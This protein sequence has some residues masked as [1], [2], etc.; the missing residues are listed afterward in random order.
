MNWAFLGYGK[1]AIQFHESLKEFSDQKVYAIASRSKADEM[2]QQY[3]D[4]VIYDNYEDLY[5]DA[6]IDI[7]YINTTHNF[8]SE[9][10][11]RCLESGKHVLCEKPIGVTFDEVKQMV[12]TARKTGKYLLEGMWT[13]YLPAYKKVKELIADGLIGDIQFIRSDFSVRFPKD[14]KGRMY[15]PALSGGGMF[16]L[17]VYNIA[18]VNDMLGRLPEKILTTGELTETG[19]DAYINTGLSYDQN[20]SAQVFC[21]MNTTTQWD[22]WIYGEKGWIRMI[23]FFRCQ[24]FIYRLEGEEEVTVEVPYKST[25]FYH[26]IEATIEHIQSGAIES[27][28]FTHQKSLDSARLV[29]DI[30]NQLFNSKK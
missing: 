22:G 14:L 29:E 4:C 24:K 30:R 19:V 7:V 20:Q 2:K 15:N 28:I 6:E 23:E 25:G 26:E 3:P 5:A 10:V 21:G 8:H 11:V 16:D 13:Q 1:I 17:G 18:L 27:N 12:D 9:Q